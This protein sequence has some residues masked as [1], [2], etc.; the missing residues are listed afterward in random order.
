MNLREFSFAI[1]YTFLGQIYRPKILTYS[2]N[3]YFALP[4]NA[5][6]FFVVSNGGSTRCDVAIS[7]DGISIGRWRIPAWGTIQI[8]RPVDS[9]TKFL[10][11]REQYVKST[12]SQ[13]GSSTI[14]NNGLIELEF[15]PEILKELSASNPIQQRERVYFDGFSANYMYSDP[16][17]SA[18]S[19][20]T[21]KPRPTT[22]IKSNPINRPNYSGREKIGFVSKQGNYSGG[23]TIFEKNSAQEFIELKD[24]VEIDEKRKIVIVARLLLDN[25]N[26][27]FFSAPKTNN[28]NTRNYMGPPSID[29]I[30]FPN[31]FI[32]K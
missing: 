24:I 10:F 17:I 31:S 23:G 28:N 22:S 7:L 18:T 9:N 32:T 2:G 1:Q 21:Q 13:S 25:F 27:G 14:S 16:N 19:I 6:Y 11:V 12:E 5:E 3:T 30:Y 4:E 26:P 15:F 8:E 29:K 20:S